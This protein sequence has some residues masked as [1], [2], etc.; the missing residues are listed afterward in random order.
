MQV[1]ANDLLGYLDRLEHLRASN[2]TQDE[3]K[4]VTEEIYKGFPEPQYCVHFKQTR[5]IVVAKYEEYLNGFKPKETQSEKPKQSRQ[6]R[7]SAKSTKK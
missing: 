7:T 5:A 3:K 1:T 6:R 4:I 2:L